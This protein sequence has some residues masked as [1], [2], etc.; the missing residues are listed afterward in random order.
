MKAAKTRHLENAVNIGVVVILGFFLLRPGGILR[1]M[2]DPARDYGGA[3]RREIL[4]KRQ[5]MELWQEL[6]RGARV[7]N[8]KGEIH[9]VVFSDYVCPACRR[10]YSELQDA[11]AR[12]PDVGIVFR[13]LPLSQHPVARAAARAAVCAEEQGRFHRMHEYLFET[14]AWQ[15]HVSWVEVADNAGIEDLKEFERCLHADTTN[16]R[17][18]MDR[19]LAR[20]IGISQTPG[21]VLRNGVLDGSISMT[22][23][24]D[25]AGR[26]FE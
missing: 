20:E 25:V 18:Q 3:A 6:I 11:L 13:H 22:N 2:F 15:D 19:M 10:E 9:L 17:L 24:L 5:F 7:D 8:R 1:Q 16:D 23:L 21:Y 12:H 4:S 26:D 14:S